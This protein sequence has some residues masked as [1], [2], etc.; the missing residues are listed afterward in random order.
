MVVKENSICSIL[1]RP[2]YWDFTIWQIQKPSK[3]ELTGG[4]SYDKSV[5]LYFFIKGRIS[6]PAYTIRVCFRG[7]VYFKH[8]THCGTASV[9]FQ[10]K[11]NNW[12]IQV[13][14]CSGHT[15][16]YLCCLNPRNWGNSVIILILE[17]SFVCK[18]TWETLGMQSQCLSHFPTALS[19]LRHN[20]QQHLSTPA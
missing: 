19:C 11:R 15:Y 6:S 4:R 8:W 1:S 3:E 9:F 5:C 13:S 17:I 2:S 14:L 10:H 12:P 7:W 20:P 18:V 16:K